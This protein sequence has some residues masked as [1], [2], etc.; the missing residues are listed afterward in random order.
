M[1]GVHDPLTL[2]ALKA[3]YSREQLVTERARLAAEVLSGVTLT[4][5]GMAGA[6]GS[7][8]IQATPAELLSIVQGLIDQYDDAS[9]PADQAAPLVHF[10]AALYQT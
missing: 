9:S 6:N 5:L 3:V 4:S 1:P 7:G 8:V 10:G 2:K